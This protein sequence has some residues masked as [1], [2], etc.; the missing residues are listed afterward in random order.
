MCGQLA[1][2][3]ATCIG[4]VTNVDAGTGR[5]VVLGAIDETLLDIGG[6][7]VESFVDVDIALRRDLEKRDAELVGQ[8]LALLC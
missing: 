3:A 1:T 7:T 8:S 5:L 6:Q 4:L 2:L